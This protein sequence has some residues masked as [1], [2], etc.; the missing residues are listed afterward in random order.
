MVLLS[1]FKNYFLLIELIL[2]I[3]IDGSGSG[4]KETKGLTWVEPILRFAR[5]NVLPLGASLSFYAF[6]FC[7]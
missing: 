4:G 1:V 2:E 5:G 7:I 6:K 3:Q